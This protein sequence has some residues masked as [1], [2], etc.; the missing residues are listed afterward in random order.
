MV[1]LFLAWD[2]TWLK[3]GNVAMSVCS[4]LIRP[5]RSGHGSST[6]MTLSH[7]HCLGA[8]ITFHMWSWGDS[9]VASTPSCIMLH[10]CFS[11]HSAC[12]LDL[13]VCIPA[14]LPHVPF[15]SGLLSA[16]WQWDLSPDQM[17]VQAWHFLSRA[18]SVYIERFVAGSWS[19]PR[20]LSFLQP[21]PESHMIRWCFDPTW[22][23][24]VPSHFAPASRGHCNTHS[25]DTHGSSI[26]SS[27]PPSLSHISGHRPPWFTI[28]DH[29]QF[30]FK[31]EILWSLLHWRVLGST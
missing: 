10:Q 13:G 9:W 21:Q 18:P 22:L 3:T 19:E 11:A 6:L 24:S 20:S 1:A 7:P 25:V 4:I 23:F 2:I 8:K 14:F 29:L 26:T 12:I 17:Q 28:L 15:S 27:V 16:S 31:D 30:L 5:P